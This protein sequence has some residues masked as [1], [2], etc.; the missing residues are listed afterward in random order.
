MAD[1]E[2]RREM[3]RLWRVY[4]TSKQMCFDRVSTTVITTTTT[5]MTMIMTIDSTDSCAQVLT[6]RCR[7][8]S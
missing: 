3:S 6:V 8:M 4:K 2:N 5:T 7:A 1:D